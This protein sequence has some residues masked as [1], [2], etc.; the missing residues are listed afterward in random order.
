[1]YDMSENKGSEARDLQ[2]WEHTI[3]RVNNQLW[4]QDLPVHGFLQDPLASIPPILAD[5]FRGRDE[6]R[7]VCNTFDHL[8]HFQHCSPEGLKI[9]VFMKIRGWPELLLQADYRF[10]E[11]AKQ[12]GGKL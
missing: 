4:F 12:V 3:F 6:R 10:E 1:M 9:T 7:I 11:S 2:S 5:L 8:L